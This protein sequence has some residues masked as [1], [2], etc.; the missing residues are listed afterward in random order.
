MHLLVRS[1]AVVF[2]V[3]AS[4]CVVTTGR[5]VSSPPPAEERHAPPPPQDRYIEGTV[6]DAVSRQPI[7][8]AA[9]DIT[10]PAL[11]DKEMTANTD[12]SGHYRTQTLPPGAFSIRV[13]R[14]GFEV[15]DRPVNVTDG[16][17]RLDIQLTPK[18]GR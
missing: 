7:G 8:R 1:F 18:H 16:P 5:P 13:R 2:F 14:E 9:I 11:G 15:V 17:A 10:S 3:G 4:A 6:T 12:A